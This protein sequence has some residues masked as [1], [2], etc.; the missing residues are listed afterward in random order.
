[1]APCILVESCHCFG[2]MCPSTGRPWRWRE[3]VLPNR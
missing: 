1:M 3:N 2:E